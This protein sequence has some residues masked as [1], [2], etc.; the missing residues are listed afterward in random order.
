MES[1][2]TPVVLGGCTQR[3]RTANILILHT[4]DYRAKTGQGFSGT[5]C[6]V[7]IPNT[8]VHVKTC[9]EWGEKGSFEPSR[10][11]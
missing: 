8:R 5:P 7:D 6:H 2:G 9:G 4:L 3:R 11:A 1:D 10:V